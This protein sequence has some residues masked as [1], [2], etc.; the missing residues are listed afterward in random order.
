MEN[1][2]TIF[3][4]LVGSSSYG[5]F[6]EGKSDLDYKGL[7]IQNPREILGFNYKEQM[8][9]TKDE[10]YYEVRRFLELIKI[11]NPTML[12]LLATPED[13]IIEKDKVFDI[14]LREKDKFITKKALHSFSG[15]AYAQIK[16][17]KGQNKKVNSY[18]KYVDEDGVAILKKRI[19]EMDEK[20]NRMQYNALRKQFCRGL[21]DF[22]YKGSGYDLNTFV[23]SEWENID[24]DIMYCIQSDS[25]VPK[26]LPPNRYNYFWFVKCFDTLSHILPNHF[27]S[28]ENVSVKMPFRPAKYNKFN[29][30]DLACVEHVDNLFR[31]YKDGTGIKFENDD[32]KVTS[33]PKEREWKDFTGV[34]YYNNNAYQND[35]REYQSFWEWMANKNEARWLN[36]EKGQMDFDAK[37]MMHTMRLLIQSEYILKDGEPKIYFEGDEQKYLMDIRLGKYDYDT[38]LKQAEI[39]CLELK[40]KF[41]KST[42]PY[43]SDYKKINELYKQLMEM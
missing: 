20:R 4:A 31:I 12:E 16:K 10:T 26:M 17:A 2:K 43:G 28:H 40:D 5:T 35:L 14:I 39:K 41:E 29:D 19:G 21:A 8:N 25:G 27:E 7:Y 38:L 18:D 1:Y 15:Y 42:L 24:E 11:A 37:N 3:K 34:L 32:L 6:V 13:C 33:I 23:H 22:I 36:Q 30:V 9:V